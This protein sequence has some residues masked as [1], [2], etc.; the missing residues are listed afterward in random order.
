MKKA[1]Q[2]Q[3]SQ[4]KKRSA[5][6]NYST[7]SVNEMGQL[8]ERASLLNQRIVEGYGCI[9]G[10]RNDYGEMVVRGAYAKS[11]Q[12]M[13]PGTNSNYQIKFRDE[14]GRA[15]ALFDVL[16]EDEIGLYFRTKPLDEVQWCDDLLTQLR[17]GTINNFSNGFKFIWDKIEYDTDNDAL[18]ILEARLFEISAVAIPADMETF[19]I[20]SIEDVEILNEQTEN[21]IISLP[22]HKQLEA[23]KLFTRYTS[24]SQTE[25]LEQ[26]RKALREEIEPSAAGID[27]SA[28][29]T[30]ISQHSLLT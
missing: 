25:P 5:P 2:Q 28:L 9:W 16:K 18:V 7:V 24:L 27:Y 12:E 6:I 21:F 23:R 14:H 17:S 8:Q 19:A 4:L 10:V 22:P 1:T 26:R 29:R 30:E 15:C 11:I 3:I 20:R 13:G